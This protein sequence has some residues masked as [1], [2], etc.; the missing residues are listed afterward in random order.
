MGGIRAKEMKMEAP[1]M[2][3]GPQ[4]CSVQWRGKRIRVG[5]FMKAKDG[6]PGFTVHQ[7]L[8]GI[9]KFNKNHET[10]LRLISPPVAER[11]V[12]PASMFPDA[13][14]RNELRRDLMSCGLPT[15]YPFDSG[16]IVTNTMFANPAP[17]SPLPEAVSSK[18]AGGLRISFNTGE[19]RGRKTVVLAQGVG[20]ESLELDE[21]RISF[22][23]NGASSLIQFP[24]ATENGTVALP[25]FEE[26]GDAARVSA[27]LGGGPGF[28]A[29]KSISR[30][31]FACAGFLAR[32]GSRSNPEVHKK[33]HFSC[34]PST[35]FRI[36]LTEIPARDIRAFEKHAPATTEFNRVAPGNRYTYSVYAFGG[37]GEAWA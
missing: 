12:N 3:Y 30:N 7:I 24:Q 33:I 36:V 20:P 9:S 8:G 25:A 17:W 4:A 19:Y 31:D 29:G 22:T 27:A 13:R 28:L 26:S 18:A 14:K 37:R 5:V 32:E 10:G 23:P 34:M 11:V 35:E 21:K 15:Q 2:K 1:N 6:A 16:L